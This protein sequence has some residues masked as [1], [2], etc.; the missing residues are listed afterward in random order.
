VHNYKPSDRRYTH[1]H[2]S[3]QWEENLLSYL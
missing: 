2:D 3:D 1:A